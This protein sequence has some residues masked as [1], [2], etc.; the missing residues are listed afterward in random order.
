[1]YTF[2]WQLKFVLFVRAS[3][4]ISSYN[5]Y[6]Q[7]NNGTKNIAFLTKNYGELNNNAEIVESF[8]IEY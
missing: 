3:T 4:F 1:M 8:W 7:P 6:L 5:T 2:E